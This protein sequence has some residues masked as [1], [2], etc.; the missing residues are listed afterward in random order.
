MKQM[1]KQGMS[2]RSRAALFA[3]MSRHG[4]YYS[5]VPRPQRRLH[6]DEP[7]T[8]E[9]VKNVALD[10]PAFGYRKVW[11]HLRGL[12]GLFIN[13][14]RVRRILKEE[15][16]QKE[17]HFPR[18]RLPETGSM[19][20]SQPNER[21]AADITYV[22]TTDIGPV[23]LLAVMDTRTREIVSYELMRSIG[24]AE[25]L[26]IVGRGVLG[27]FPKTGRAPGLV[28]K[29]DG[30]P[31]FVAHRFQD[32]MRMLGI[33]LWANRKRRPE[34]NGKIESFNG[35]FKH[36]YLWI[37]EPETYIETRQVVAEGMKDYNAMRPHSSLRYLTPREFMRRKVAEMEG[38]RA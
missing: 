10:H 19:A 12:D 17:M 32:G 29:T 33:T 36:E 2:S 15:G 26:E 6:R 27:R 31:Q 18:P 3:G 5:P 24:A 30:G 9:M 25:A 4:T 8:R 34:N 28:L 11:A 21:W 22:E 37:R 35:H 38:T 13:R 23:P 16:L 14:K 1:L 7:R 20:A